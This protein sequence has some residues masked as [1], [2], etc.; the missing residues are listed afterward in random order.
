MKKY[1][2]ILFFFILT[3][4]FFYPVVKGLQPIPADTIVGLYHPFRDL[5]AGDYP[6]GIPFKNFLI[7]DPVRQQYP[8][9]FLTIL[10]EKK[11]E[12]PLWNPYNFSGTPL[13]ANFQSGAFYP[14]NS[15]FFMLPFSLGWTILIFLQ[16]LLGG[17]FLYY[18]LKN[19]NL[20]YL[21]CILG[22]I[23]FG[24][25][26]FS[27]AWMEWG[28]IMH[29]VIW[30]PLILLAKE[31]L[32]RKR[33]I[34]WFITLIFAECSLFFAGHLQTFFYAFLISNIYLFGRIWQIIQE[35]K[36]CNISSA[37][38][39]YFPFFLTGLI[40]ISIYLIQLIPTL[41]LLS[42]SARDVD[43]AIWQKEGWF[44]PWQ[45]LVQFLS[46]D[47]F[48]N[49]TT[50]NYFGVWNYGEF[51]GYVGILPL[52]FAFFA[53]G[54]RRDKKT[55]FFGSIFFASLLFS[56]P[57]IFA[58]LPYILHVP[59]IST[60]QPTR[61]LFLTDISLAILSALGLDF[62]L[63]KPKKMSI[64]IGLIAMLFSGVWVYILFG[65]SLFLEQNLL[66]ATRNLLIPSGIFISC[67]VLL[68]SYIYLPRNRIK[69]PIILLLFV[70]TVFDLF[71][72]GW[73]FLPFTNS[74]YL[75]PQTKAINFLQQHVGSQRVMSLDS[76]ILPPNFAMYYKLQD[77]AGYDPLYLRRYAELISS[78]ERGEPDIQ[79]PFGFNRIITPHNV[80]SKIIDLLGVKYVMSL[81]DVTDSA[82]IKVFQEGETQIYENKNVLPRV[83][84]VTNIIET[85]NKD[86]AIEEIY[87]PS[88]SFRETAIIEKF[89]GEHFSFPKLLGK[90]SA[91]II[92]YSENRILIKT[93]VIHDGFLVFTDTFYPTW[94]AAIHTNT[95]ISETTIFRT[96]Y[97]FRGIIVPK[98]EHIVEFY[99][100]IW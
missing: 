74:Q 79:P 65:K 8:W 49:P 92:S 9:R 31:K 72:F 11:G 67:L 19:F 27:I 36:T 76:R 40:V 22:G 3:L 4:S 56:L 16:P 60:S 73:K 45:H 85:T 37:W 38:K 80:D 1:F 43:Q 75:F 28:T 21:A 86:A 78:S 17:V 6:R 12:L 97:N 46:P 23:V 20:S 32:L 26:G 91:E 99:N 98:G 34:T 61:L 48:G 95:R 77:I 54:F 42:L 14:L 5:Y 90:G 44:I 94:H 39:L 50:L 35:K 84:F 10:L 81:S 7:T 30:L 57:T 15:I 13:L 68:L 47:F 18:Y 33:T 83:F 96:N 66:I 58:K 24:F 53:L 88:F 2:P 89:V 87:K 100:T 51:I 82:L 41:Q 62:F 63:K 93:N 71:R 59:F 70:L 69:F 29:T 52:L 64:I 25:C 55:L